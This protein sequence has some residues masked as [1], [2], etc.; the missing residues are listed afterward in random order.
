MA[1]DYTP[2]PY[3]QFHAWQNNLVTYVNGHLADL[4]LA[5][6]DVGALTP[7]RR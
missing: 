2:R 3:A 4:G 1:N 6:G 5:A 7:Q